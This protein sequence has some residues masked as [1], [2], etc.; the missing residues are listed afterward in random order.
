ME[1]FYLQ[2]MN[3]NQKTTKSKVKTSY[4][5]E[6]DTKRRSKILGHFQVIL[7]DEVHRN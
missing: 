1:A 7:S 6:S 2:R 4:W 3:G 5:K